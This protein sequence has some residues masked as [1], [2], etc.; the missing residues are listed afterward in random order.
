MDKIF[1]DLVKSMDAAI[2]ALEGEDIITV[3]T[4]AK[5]LKLPKCDYCLSNAKYDAQTKQGPWAYMCNSHFNQ[6]ARTK[7][8]GLGLGQELKVIK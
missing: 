8:L 3:T 7:K 5:V 2:G 6:H 1:N 4:T